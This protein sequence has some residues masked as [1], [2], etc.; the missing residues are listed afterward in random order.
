MDVILYNPKTSRFVE[1]ETL[2][3]RFQEHTEYEIGFIETAF[4]NKQGMTVECRNY[5]VKFRC[6]ESITTILTRPVNFT[7]CK[8]YFEDEVL[9]FLS[10]SEREY[11]LNYQVVLDGLS[12]KVFNMKLFHRATAEIFVR[13]TGRLEIYDDAK[14]LCLHGDY[15]HLPDEGEKWFEKQDTEVIERLINFLLLNGRKETNHE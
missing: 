14:G 13:A 8:A 4:V 3:F 9:M 7:D 10:P 5:G 11:G 2:G 1:V 15:F 6:G 12:V